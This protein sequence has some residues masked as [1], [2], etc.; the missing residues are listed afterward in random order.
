VKRPVWVW[1]VLAVIVGAV[2]T[3]LAF[4]LGLRDKPPPDVT[5]GV[6]LVTPRDRTSH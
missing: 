4:G 6:E 2:I 5:N 1:I 3:W